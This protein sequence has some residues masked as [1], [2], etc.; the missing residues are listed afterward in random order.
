MMSHPARKMGVP[1]AASTAPALINPW[2]RGVD[3]ADRTC[4]MIGCV[5]RPKA[6]GLCGKHYQSEKVAGRLDSHRGPRRVGPMDRRLL[7]DRRITESGCWE[8]TGEVAWNGY[9]MLS[10]QGRRR[11]THRIA[12][13]LWVGPIPEGLQLDHLCRNRACFNPDHLEPVTRQENI[14]RG[15]GIPVINAAK[16][17]C[18]KG[19]PYNEANTRVT[20]L[21]QRKCRECDRE[22]HHRYYHEVV[23][24]RLLQREAMDQ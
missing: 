7:D 8:F 19:H 18:P 12:Y 1:G 5:G 15:V 11:V 6:R 9:G 17:H 3:V 10:E 14:R 4:S 22:R 24:P 13:E 20:K 21:N 23:K 2:M 16:T